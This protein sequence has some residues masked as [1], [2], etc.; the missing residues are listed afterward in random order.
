LNLLIA[1]CLSGGGLSDQRLS[2]S[3]LSEAYAM[4]NCLISDLKAAGHNVTTTLDSRLKAFNP[5]N[6]ADKIEPV[7]STA[8]FSA[9]LQ[10]LSDSVDAVYLIAP[11]SGNLLRNF[12]KL[13]K[14]SGGTLLNCR[15][16]AIKR[17]SNKLAL[18]DLAERVGLKTPETVVL[19]IN[20]TPDSIRQAICELGYPMVF[21]PLDGVGC[22]GLS[23]VKNEDNVPSAVKKASY[24][25]TGRQFI[26]QK[27]VKGEAASVCVISDGKEALPITLNR[28]LITLETPEGESGYL[29]G[30]VPFD[31]PMKEEAFA[32]ARK[33]VDAVGGLRGYVGVDMILSEEGPVVVEVNPR[34][35]TSYVGLRKAVNF[36]PAQ[37]IVE[38]VTAGVLPE[39]VDTERY[40]FFGKVEVPV[41]CH[42]FFEAT[43]L[44]EVVS[45]PF[46]L[47]GESSAYA[48]VAVASTSPEL[49]QAKFVRIKNR[50]LTL[51]GGQ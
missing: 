16:D 36:N 42:V 34:L 19:D 9:K 10:S 23:L 7:S 24:E 27:L 40:A 6:K 51:C 4:I 47:E 48:L 30:A 15:V 29:G 22:G 49:A 28:Q 18:I 50:L 11:E 44:E 20:E 39:N 45:P 41:S 12:V 37:T 38:A 46:Q 17:A 13:V 2:T 1:E 26:A 31:H 43:E 14:D 5:P 33:I 21:K 32:A 8:E 35:T 25:S 3:V